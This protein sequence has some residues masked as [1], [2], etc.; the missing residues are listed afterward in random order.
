MCDGAWAVVPVLCDMSVSCVR[1]TTSTGC[2]RSA[3]SGGD[4][5]SAD[6]G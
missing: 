3:G 6:A 1:S 4:G 2:E 5:S